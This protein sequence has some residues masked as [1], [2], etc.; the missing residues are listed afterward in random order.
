MSGF[1]DLERQL[2]GAVRGR[3]AQAPTDRRGWWTGRALALAAALVVP[4]GSVA[5]A[6]G[7]LGSDDRARTQDLFSSAVTEAQGMP[8][9]EEGPQPPARYSDAA[10]QPETLDAFGFLRRPARPG[11]TVPQRWRENPDSA[12]LGGV[13]LAD[14]V[15]RLEAPDGSVFTVVV[16]R[17]PAALG[18]RAADPRSCLA[19]Q[20]QALDRAAATEPAQVREAAADLMARHQA[21]WRARLRGDQLLVLHATG[22][23]TGSGGG[24]PAS[25]AS[26]GGVS[27]VTYA[28]PRE[29]P[30]SFAGVVPDGVAQ[31]V[32]ETDEDEYAGD[33][34]DN[35]FAF[36]VPG[37][38][39]D[40]FR[41]TVTWRDASGAII[42]ES[43][44]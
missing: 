44:G 38:A 11:D 23:S 40:F 41:A 29:G 2:R 10:P 25:E 33:V 26:E 8:A 28:G 9:C 16:L 32:V 21:Q 24:K 37:T 39:D 30:L 35:T 36:E 4:A 17:G 18:R 6:A 13:I 3:A 15:R 5:V 27:S 7:M 31:V 19:A 22:S 20:A 43:P 14:Y 34:V 42:R 1:D 12:P